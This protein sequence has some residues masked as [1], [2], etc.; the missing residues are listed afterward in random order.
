MVKSSNNQPFDSSATPY[1]QM[2]FL[3]SDAFT[4]FINLI[5]EGVIISNE[6]GNI[7]LANNT[8][9]NQFQYTPQEFQSITIESLV[10][11]SIRKMHVDMRRSFFEDPKPRHLENRGLNLLAVK[12]DQT[13]FPMESALFAIHTE[14]GT[15]AVNM[16]QD[17][18]QRQEDQRKISEYAFIDALTNLPNRRYFDATIERT[19]EKAK[20]HQQPLALL[21]IDLD[22]FK[23]INDQYGHD[24]GDNVLMQMGQRIAGSIRKE[25][26]LAR[27]G[28]DE[29]VITIFPLDNKNALNY[30]LDR[31]IEQCSLPIHC[32]DHT[33]Q[34][35]ASIGI[36]IS[37][38]ADFNQQELLE[39]A[40][41]A[42]YD[43]K[44]KGGNCY[45]YY[46][47]ASFFE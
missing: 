39:Q 43:A 12:K 34:L 1:W 24:I 37:S 28:G 31:I 15:L 26:F 19:T 3:L 29:F 30:V 42:M 46:L 20:R 16:I 22:H 13:T 6:Q 2:D 38:Q 23:P 11:E 41:K 25:D 27:V 45:V 5:P 40:D 17:V 10:P 14:Q 32:G 4:D 33:F 18:S 36:S 44:A 21:F 8:A 35:S 9:C 47:N 7:V